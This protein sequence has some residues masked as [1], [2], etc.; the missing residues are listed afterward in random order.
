MCKFKYA[1]EYTLESNYER[2]DVAYLHFIMF[3]KQIEGHRNILQYKFFI[4]CITVKYHRKK[5]PAGKVVYW[6]DMILLSFSFF[7]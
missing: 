6:Q 4:D 7:F 5:A 2:I 3:L 1:L